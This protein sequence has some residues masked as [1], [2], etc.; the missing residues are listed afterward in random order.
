VI[1]EAVPYLAGALGASGLA[2]WASRRRE[3]IRRWLTW[4][5][6]APVVTL[7]LLAGPL[8][9]GLLA[10]ALGV[11][12]AV[13]Y[14]RLVRL[15]RPET[16]VLAMAVAALP[17]TEAFDPHV[18]AQEAAAGTGVPA[19][20][21]GGGGSLLAGV[22]LVLVLIPVLS[23]DAADGGRRAAYAVFGLLWLA[24]LSMLV[25]LVPPTAF[26]LCLAVALA[27]VSA[28][29][30]GRLIK[31]PALSPL[32]PA[33]TWGGVVGGAVGG[34]AVL[35]V[36]GALTPVT[37]LAVAV[38]APL[39]DLL[40]SMFK[41]GAGVKDAGTWLPG[42]GGLLDRLDSLLVALAVMAVL[43]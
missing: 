41:R 21:A 36:L 6:A 10:A 22:L 13:E 9:A 37:A 12:C 26:A 4:A 43:A 39:G 35:A 16:G 11:V 19:V 29:C 14:S 17:L 28:W 8:G 31:G 30:G 24:P 42:F 18:Q 27:D 38:G 1:V 20:L 5:V 25:V 40:E 3:L 15:R 2:V 7:A 34:L 23:G 33:K 32:S